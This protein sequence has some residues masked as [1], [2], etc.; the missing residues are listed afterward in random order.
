MLRFS[1]TKLST[2]LYNLLILGKAQMFV[3]DAVL[4]KNAV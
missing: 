2:M 1:I 3:S 4:D